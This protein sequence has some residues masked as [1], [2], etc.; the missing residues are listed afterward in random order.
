MSAPSDRTIP[1]VTDPKSLMLY[2]AALMLTEMADFTAPSVP[3]VDEP[4]NYLTYRLVSALRAYLIFL[5]GQDIANMLP[6]EVVGK[7]RFKIDGTFQLW[8]AND[9]AYRT[10]TIAGAGNAV[11]F[12]IGDPDPDL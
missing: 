2:K 10:I 1:A 5:D 6:R 3:R 4:M 12:E 7:Y 11:H 9:L 8:N